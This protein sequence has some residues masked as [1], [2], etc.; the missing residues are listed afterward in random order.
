MTVERLPGRRLSTFTGLR[1]PAVPSGRRLA[2]RVAPVLAA[3]AAVFLILPALD[4]SIEDTVIRAT[5]FLLTG[6]AVAVPARAGLVN[7]GGEGQLL[8]GAVFATWGAL[9]LGARLPAP[10]LLPLLALMG[11]LGGAIWASIAAGMRIA[12]QLNE[13]ISTLLLNFVATLVL[14]YMVHGPWKDPESF[15]LPLTAEFTDAARLPAYGFT[16]L[17][18]GILIAAIAAVAVW[19]VL[20]LTRLGFRLRVVGGN[21]EA[22]RRAGIPVPGYVFVALIAGGGLAG[23]AG[24]IEV[25][26]IESRLRPDIAVGFGYIGF[27]ASWLVGHRPVAIVGAAVLLGAIS[28]GGDSLQIDAGLPSASVYILMA[29]V[30]LVVLGLRGSGR[31][32]EA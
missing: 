15:N 12:V 20:D 27:L 11:I 14:A 25:S 26:G 21:A 16:Q 23:L 10:I 4:V 5:P 31:R 17:H 19:I 28:V 13:T 29:L 2:R 30:L 6:L 18:L 1:R 8:L 9:E 3:V 24:M 32:R 7:V 22:A